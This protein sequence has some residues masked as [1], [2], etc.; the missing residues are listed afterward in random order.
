MPSHDPKELVAVMPSI[1]PDVQTIIQ[2]TP[3]PSEEIYCALGAQSIDTMKKLTKSELTESTT[4]SYKYCQSHPKISRAANSQPS[5]MYSTPI[6]KKA[7]GRR[8]SIFAWSLRTS[9]HRTTRCLLVIFDVE[10][11][12]GKNSGRVD[13]KYCVYEF[14][15]KGCSTRNGKGSTLMKE[16]DAEDIS[17][18]ANEL[19]L[20]EGSIPIPENLEGCSH[21]V[22]REELSELVHGVHLLCLLTRGRIVHNAFS[23]SLIQ[24]SLLSLLPVNLLTDYV[25]L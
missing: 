12:V 4:P 5:T 22:G 15:L 19:V 23:D 20:K 24:A 7:E 2:M 8:R 16:G 17:Y 11:S 25:P 1:D 9:H 21:D 18:D 13:T 14:N 3:T 10:E 6:L